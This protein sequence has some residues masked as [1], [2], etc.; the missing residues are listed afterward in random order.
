MPINPVRNAGFSGIPR[1]HI[2]HRFAPVTNTANVQ[3][4]RRGS[5]APPAYTPTPRPGER[6][7][8]SNPSRAP[9]APPYGH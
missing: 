7:I 6:T 1:A 4:S 5:E 8:A 3:Q 2:D 9:S